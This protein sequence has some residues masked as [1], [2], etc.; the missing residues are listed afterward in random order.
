V[1]ESVRNGTGGREWQV[2]RVNLIQPD[3]LPREIAINKRNA[4]KIIDEYPIHATIDLCLKKCLSGVTEGDELISKK[5]ICERLLL[6]IVALFLSQVNGCG[7]KQKFIFVWNGSVLFFAPRLGIFKQKAFFERLTIYH[8]PI[9]FFI[10]SKVSPII[11]ISTIILVFG[12][13][14]C[15]TKPLLC[16]IILK[17]LMRCLST[18]FNSSEPCY[19]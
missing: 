3:D 7:S 4:A 8:I 9:S 15:L 6:P 17:S 2:C 10:Y 14:R 1:T 16:C 11:D 5:L 13:V 18:I 12:F 19:G